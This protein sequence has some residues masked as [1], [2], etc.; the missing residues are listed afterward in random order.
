V[1]VV[2]VFAASALHAFDLVKDG[3]PSATVVIAA[4]ASKLITTA[5]DDFIY[6]VKLMTGATL[7]ITKDDQELAAGNRVYLGESKHTKELGIEVSKLPR[8]GFRILTT[9]NALAIVG[10]DKPLIAYRPNGSVRKLSDDPMGEFHWAHPATWYGVCHYLEKY[11]DVRWFWP[12]EEGVYYRKSERVPVEKID[13]V[14][15]PPVMWRVMWSLMQGNW[16]TRGFPKE[17]F[18]ETNWGDPS[19]M[20]QEYKV[21]ERRMRLGKAGQIKVSHKMGFFH[22]KYYQERRE[23]FAQ[24]L[25]GTRNWPECWPTS[26]I[27]MCVSHPDVAKILIERG[28]ESLGR[29]HDYNIEWI[30]YD[31]G[32]N[33][34]GGWC[35]CDRCKALDPRNA[36]KASYSGVIKKGKTWASKRIHHVA[37]TDR[38]ATLWNKVATALGKDYPDELIG[39]VIYSACSSPPVRE[40]LHRNIILAYSGGSDFRRARPL[41][42]IKRELSRWFA[43]GLR[44]FYWRPNFMYFDLKGLPFFYADEAGE[45]IRYLTANGAKGFHFD[46]WQNNFATDGINVYVVLRVMWNPELDVR[47]LIKEY[48]DKAFGRAGREVHDYF[49]VCKAIRDKLIADKD[50]ALPP[51]TQDYQ[52]EMYRYFDEETLNDLEARAKRIEELAKGDEEQF[53]KR[54]EVFLTGVKYTLLQGRSILY[55]AKKERT[56]KHLNRLVTTIRE[57]EEFIENLGPSWAIC[58]PSIRWWTKLMK[59]GPAL[60]WHYYEPFKGKQIAALL[61][62]RWKFYI[63]Q[64]ESGEDKKL[65]TD[66]FNDSDLVTLSIRKLWEKQGFDYNGIAWYRTRFEAP[67]KAEGKRYY[68]WFGAID[69]GFWLYVNGQKVGEDFSTEERP[70]VWYTPYCCEVTD[71]LRYGEE[72]LIAVKVRDIL[73]AGGIYKGAFLLVD[74]QE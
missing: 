31:M 66:A 1:A 7:P 73:G 41:E 45:L 72:N 39:S 13:E 18:E 64:T 68:L 19:K 9:D 32:F 51:R 2:G 71:Q 23:L 6:H 55:L 20:V 74:A 22:Q 27:K 50:P 57:K 43:A 63:D 4:D 33:D 62:D 3:K 47:E 28:R 58:T 69:D 59:F 61:P 70:H 54:V 8:E 42:P 26:N 53:R 17:M 10:K 40:K 30:T 14:K 49:M 65:H 48:C 11:H 25:D 5:A 12:G 56:L 24:Q 38:Y 34:S 29:R 16:I 35:F 60:G 37:L 67:K 46:T 36:P 52:G 15:A 21:W 44:N